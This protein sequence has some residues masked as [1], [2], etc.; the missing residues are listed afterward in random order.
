MTKAA[1]TTIDWAV[2]I[3]YFMWLVVIGVVV[4]RRVKDTQSYFLGNRGFS[5]WLMIAQSFGVGT[6]AEQPVALAGSVY[7]SGFAAIW[8][9]W[10][11][12]F[13]TPFYWLMAPIF[14]RC[15]RTTIAEIVEDRYGTGMG[16]LYILFALAFFVLNT[17]TMLTGASKVISAATDGE[18]GVRQIIFGMTVTFI[19]YSFVGGL[20]AAAWTDFFQSFLIL[21]LSFMLLP[22]GWSQVGGMS[23]MKATIAHPAFFSLATPGDITPGLIFALTLNGLIGI[24]AQPHI[25]ASVGTGKDESACRVGF[26]YGTFVKRF[27][28]VGWA[29]VGLLV[30]ALPLDSL[31]KSALQRDPELAFGLACHA[32][33]L[34]G[35]LGLLIACVLAANMS[36]CSA[37]MVDSGALFTRGFYDRFIAPGRSDKH[38]LWVGRVSGLVITL[39]GVAYA[40]FYVKSVLF[41]FLLTETLATYFGISLLGGLIWRRANRYGAAA[42]FFTALAISFGAH[43]L[44]HTR[45]DKFDPAV[46][47]YSLVGGIFALIIVSVLTPPE[48]GNAGDLFLRLNTPVE[49]NH[50]QQIV[51]NKS[52]EDEIEANHI[53]AERGALLL[54]VNML[55]LRK[56]AGHLPWTRAYRRDLTGFLVA[57]CIVAVMIGGAWLFLQYG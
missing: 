56:A 29:L 23:G 16:L 38:Y 43:A 28:T 7:H 10:K 44:S 35:L 36:A 40:L 49:L 52:T 42:S 8:Y 18:Y 12:M 30:L 11:N 39:L 1:L 34:P 13:A 4:A 20:V 46:F 31:Q 47:G 19:L 15:R 26:T 27:C 48:D 57:W 37:F 32:L 54:L 25:L 5:K 14:R 33:L 53:A 45:L 24:M 3:G 21:A 9:Q 6:H 17:G 2:I 55:Q 50:D 51:Q 22:L 41:S